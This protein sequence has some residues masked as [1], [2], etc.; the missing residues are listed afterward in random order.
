MR[1]V[2]ALLALTLLAG[3]GSAPTADRASS[4]S[5]SPS[6]H[7]VSTSYGQDAALIA[8]R[9]DGCSNV[10]SM[11]IGNGAASGMVG[12]AG[13]TLMGHQ[14]VIYTW[15]DAA[16]QSSAGALVAG[17]LKFF[18]SGTGWDQVLGDDA[19]PDAQRAIATA[20]ARS[21]GGAVSTSP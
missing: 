20:V 19:A 16:S 12:K 15:R 5:S 18:A 17:S 14:V 6:S 13:C 21:L 3:C 8:S 10:A 11:G 2:A 1:P 4:V 7:A 9:I